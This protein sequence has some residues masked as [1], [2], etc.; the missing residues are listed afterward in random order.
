MWVAGQ[1]DRYR[2]AGTDTGSG[3]REAECDNCGVLL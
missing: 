1:T 3:F 2:Q